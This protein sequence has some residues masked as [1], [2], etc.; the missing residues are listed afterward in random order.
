MLKISLLDYLICPSC[1]GDLSLK[2]K[3]KFKNELLEGTFTCKKCKQTFALNKGI[4]RFV[5]DTSKNFVKTEDSF[6]AKWRKHHANHQA[7]DWKNFQ[8]KWFFDRFGWKTIKRFT[9]FM[10]TNIEK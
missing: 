4:P 8:Q 6:S 7:Q 3:K 5:Q 1:G 10:K 2:T 9:N